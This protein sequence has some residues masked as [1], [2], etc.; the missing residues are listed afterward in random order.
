MLTAKMLEELVFV[1]KSRCLPI[2]DTPLCLRHGLDYGVFADLCEP[3][4]EQWG[5]AEAIRTCHT[6]SL[7]NGDTTDAARTSP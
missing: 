4:I 1:G 6:P 7:P 3:L 2:G 5:V